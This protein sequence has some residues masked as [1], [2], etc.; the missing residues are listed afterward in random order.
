AFFPMYITL[1]IS[2]K[3]NKQFAQRPFGL[4]PLSGARE[5]FA[6]EPASLDAWCPASITAARDALDDGLRPGDPDW[7]QV[8]AAVAWAVS[9]SR[10]SVST[11]MPFSAQAWPTGTSPPQQKSM[12]YLV[13][14]LASRNRWRPSRRRSRLPAI[15]EAR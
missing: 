4:L 7:P 9:T 14:T 15:P 2:V 5:T 10:S 3:N 11:L 8:P 1:S 13:K 6:R 12:P